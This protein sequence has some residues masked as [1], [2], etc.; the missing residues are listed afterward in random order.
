MLARDRRNR[1]EMKIL[2]TARQVSFGLVLLN[3]A[4]SFHFGW[5]NVCC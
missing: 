4:V 5:N 2:G 1:N 3:L